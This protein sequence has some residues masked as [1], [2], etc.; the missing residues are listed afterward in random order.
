MLNVV[1]W[2]LLI[3]IFNINTIYANNN[4]NNRDWQTGHYCS[5]EANILCGGCYIETEYPL[6][7]TKNLPKDTLI[8]NADQTKLISKGRSNFTGNV[9]VAKNNQQL[10]A[11]QVE[12][13]QDNK[14][15]IESLTAIGNIKLIEPGILITGNRAE[16]WIKNNYKIIYNSNYRIYNHHGRGTAQQIEVF[17]NGITNL[18][19]A[20][21]TTC[22]PNNN[23]WYL[24]AKKIQFNKNNGIAKAWHTKMYIKN[25]PIMYVP[26]ISF[27]IDRKRHTGFLLPTLESNSKNGLSFGVPFYWNIAD[28]YDYTINPI[29]MKK[30]GLKLN[31]QFR[32]LSDK[33]AGNI[34]FNFLPQDQINN[35]FRYLTSV[36]HQQQLHKNWNIFIKYNKASDNNYL[37][38]F[39]K[40]AGQMNQK[41][42]YNN[43]LE[44][45]LEET[46][47]NS[48]SHLEQSARLENTNKY[49]LLKF[50]ML[51]YQT[52][53]PEK[54]PNTQEQYKK[55]PEISWNANYINLPAKYRVQYKINYTNFYLANA[56]HG[57]R[58]HIL[59]SLERPLYASYG[60]LKPRL[61]ID[62]LS[63]QKLKNNNNAS[64]M[65]RA[66]PIFD[67]NSNLNFTKKLANNM[68]QTLEPK[69]YYLYIPKVA[70]ER[71]PIF[72]TNATEFSYDQ[73]FRYS[74]YNGID[75]LADTHQ[76]TFGLKTSIYSESGEEKASFKIARARYFHSLTPYLGENLGFEKWS[77]IGIAINYQ[78]NPKLLLE[79][80]I[81]RQKLNKTRSNSIDGQ[82][83]FDD[84][85]IINLGYQYSKLSTTPQHQVLSSFIWKARENIILLGKLDYDLNI[86]RT[87]FSLAGVEIHGCCLALRLAVAKS[88]LPTENISNKQYDTKFLAQ[89]IFKGLAN[90]GFGSFG[91]NYIS[92][93]IPGYRPGYSSTKH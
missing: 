15:K 57:Q 79:A 21:Y 19:N 50:K 12:V 20:S 54:G 91:S 38:N 11:N 29:Y 48:S 62:V 4:N 56:I 17:D 6:A 22:Q 36:S 64:N 77:P 40:D 26:Y 23:T 85:K 86:K 10:T 84:Q 60:Y 49:G 53:H 59:P 1:K 16:S 5:K 87:A 2:L 41:I 44:S 25:I 92:G 68:E 70:Q 28:N 67:I 78:I 66:I 74:R 30:R 58:I 3:I 69:L 31:N 63:Y 89:I 35:K 90:D 33:A 46:I 24:K 42:S 72:D 13:Q 37:Y 9:I 83:K 39:G 52:L 81:V 8:I 43:I 32:Y 75:R 14:E 82:Y 18:P 61:Q 88:L 73:L 55:I 27:P 47:Q 34:R 51:N 71:Y 45:S 93:K 65:S 80:N 7:I 76:V